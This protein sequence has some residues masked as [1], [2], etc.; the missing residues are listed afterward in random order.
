VAAQQEP[1]PN[2]KKPIVLLI[3]GTFSNLD[4]NNGQEQGVRAPETNDEGNDWW[5]V[6]SPV[7]SDLKQRLEPEGYVM[8]GDEKAFAN[9]PD[10][11]DE[12]GQI[13]PHLRTFKW[14]SENTERER[15]KAGIDL[16]DRLIELEK[17]GREYHLIG[18]SHG[19]SAIWH[20]LQQSVLRRWKSAKNADQLKLKHLKS[21]STVGTPFLHFEGAKIGSWYGK[22]ATILALIVSLL[23]SVLIGWW[24][25]Q[26]WTDE[27]NPVFKWVQT[28]GVPS[29]STN[30]STPSAFERDPESEIL[31][32][33]SAR[34]TKL[35]G[36]AGKL[37]T[38]TNPLDN[39]R[40]SVGEMARAALGS[41]KPGTIDPATPLD[42]F[43]AIAQLFFAVLLLLV[44]FVAV[45]LFTRAVRTEARNVYREIRAKN[46]AMLEFGDR[47]LGL[48][49]TQDEAISGLRGTTKIT[50]AQIVPRLTIPTETVFESDRFIRFYRFFVRMLLAPLVNRFLSP[51]LD[52][53]LLSRVAK[54]AQGHN[55]LG[56]DLVDVTEGPV[57]VEGY[58]YPPLPKEVN[59]EMIDSANEAIGR[60]ST[61]ILAKTRAELSQL[62][63]GASELSAVVHSV[64]DEL[65]GD[66]LIHTSY[67]EK[68]PVR[69]LLSLHVTTSAK[70]LAEDEGAERDAANVPWKR[71][72]LSG[73]KR[74]GWFITGL[75]FSGLAMFR[76][77]VEENPTY[78]LSPALALTGL[79]MMLGPLR[80][81]DPARSRKNLWGTELLGLSVIVL[82]GFYGF[83]SHQSRAIPLLEDI[84][85]GD[86]PFAHPALVFAVFLSAT[87]IF[88]A[89]SLTRA[90]EHPLGASTLGW[91]GLALLIGLTW[92]SDFL[93]PSEDTP[94][95]TLLFF[96]LLGVL[97]GFYKAFSPLQEAHDVLTRIQPNRT[98][99]VEEVE[100]LDSSQAGASWLE[101]HRKNVEA[102]ARKS[103]R[104]ATLSLPKLGEG[105]RLAFVTPLLFSGGIGSIVWGF[106]GSSDLVILGGFIATLVA[107]F[108]AFRPVLRASRGARRG[109]LA[110]LNLDALSFAFLGGVVFLLTLFIYQEFIR[111]PKAN[112]AENT[113]FVVP[114][115]DGQGNSQFVAVDNGRIKLWDLESFEFLSELTAPDKTWN[116]VA[117]GP[118]RQAILAAVRDYQIISVFD[119]ETPEGQLRLRQVLKSPAGELSAV[120]INSNATQLAGGTMNGFFVL[121]NIET[122][123]QLQKFRL[124]RQ[125]VRCLAFHPR[126]P[127]VAVG[128]E[129]RVIQVWNTDI[130]KPVAISRAHRKPVK[131]IAFYPEDD[132][133]ARARSFAG[134]RPIPHYPEEDFLAS[135]DEGGDVQFFHTPNP[136]KEPGGQLR[137]RELPSFLE[138]LNQDPT[139]KA[140][141][142]AFTS[143]SPTVFAVYAKQAKNEQA[144]GSL[145]FWTPAGDHLV[146]S[147]VYGRGDDMQFSPNGSE[148]VIRGNF[149][150]FLSTNSGINFRSF[151]LHLSGH[152][153]SVNSVAWSP[154][155]TRLAST[156][157][158]GTIR[159]W[160]AASGAAIGEPLTG[161]SFWV[162][163][164]AWSPDGTRLVS[165]SVDDTIRLWNAASGTA[166]GEPLTGHFWVM[167]VAWSPDGRQL[168]SASRDNTIRLWDTAS[169]DP[170]G[171][172][173]TGHSDSVMSVAWSPNG[174]R[175]VSASRDNTIRL[176]DAASGAAI[177]EPFTGHS[178]WVMSV[179]WSPDGTRFVSGSVD[180]TIRLWDAASGAAIGDPLTGHSDSVNSVA[181]SPDGTRLAS[182]SDD[183]T[184]RLWDAV[185]G[186][187]IGAPLTG[188]SNSVMSVAWSPD[189]TRLA[190]AS[191]DN[192]IRLWNVETSVDD[193]G[194]KETVDQ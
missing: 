4:D 71:N 114:K 120:A 17:E 169:G 20:A 190:S 59:Q 112:V 163:S 145:S 92:A 31:R 37:Q 104:I 138:E 27:S 2:S 171:E 115:P 109:R 94:F 58:R 185:S 153:S 52:G 147:E 116:F 16:L 23:V 88:F 165:G 128:L 35:P 25:L 132:F 156:S 24:Q 193:D 125:P 46:Q 74:A 79:A 184:I 13:K 22:S 26:R 159:L 136:E 107:T 62:A 56:C 127:L 141:N 131:K 174:N 162:K 155:G 140:V 64:Q 82:A 137:E 102:Q 113:A 57:V 55:R 144:V 87:A 121:W 124:S 167:S 158:D 90:T 43:W 146:Q 12:N 177:G 111:I 135:L 178:F 117:A 179:A 105:N 36:P 175:L 40:I 83:F 166:I 67:F 119:L 150:Q 33:R 63:W 161:H 103:S 48:W 7:W 75:L 9:E 3:H 126:L 6:K 181:W 85:A 176:W 101:D 19:G 5:Q 154:D 47:W 73:L 188:H 11:L 172:P 15:Y 98:K 8:G 142:L 32:S 44:P 69:E 80:F 70:R 10:A 194:K 30:Y 96:T 95:F 91:A 152:V 133:R 68:E 28:I 170:I 39:L 122:G 99:K 110:R 134:D 29:E 81:R 54:G 60:R 108:L 97:F 38:G 34:D 118:P 86:S 42:K 1:I 143:R 78:V 130:R 66:E 50:K 65:R 192:T 180:N 49:C 164:V 51:R 139:R 186:D 76:V 157:D 187:A 14:S 149:A 173:L 72:L 100:F 189:G 45:Y 93:L 129:N 18:H 148:L 21:W 84:W 182:A 191:D 151:S 41:T 168:A 106:S 77:E 89:L 183:E 123:S 160:D 61:E 53:Y